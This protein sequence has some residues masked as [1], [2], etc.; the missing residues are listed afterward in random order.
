MVYISCTIFWISLYVKRQE[1]I[2]FKHILV[3]RQVIRNEFE[4]HK[5]VTDPQKI[6]EV[7]A[8]LFHQIS[9][10]LFTFGL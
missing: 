1:S 9:I 6:E 7:N 5:D 8:S 4:K 10:C 2:N 3:I